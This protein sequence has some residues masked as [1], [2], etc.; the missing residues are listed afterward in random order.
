M[1]L[2]PQLLNTATFVGIDAHPDSH[3]AVAINRFKEMKGNLTFPNTKEGI[4][5]FHSWLEKIEQQ[6]DK[7]TYN[8]VMCKRY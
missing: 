8:I 7:T 2:Q 3:T 4:V 6:K 1:T 5:K